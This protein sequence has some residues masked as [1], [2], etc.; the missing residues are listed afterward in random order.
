MRPPAGR[1]TPGSDR[2][3]R[4]GRASA[5]LELGD[6]NSRRGDAPNGPRVPSRAS[7]CIPAG[8]AGRPCSRR[9]AARTR[10]AG[11]PRGRRPRSP[12]RAPAIVLTR[13][14]GRSYAGRARRA[15]RGSDGRVRVPLRDRVP[16]LRPHSRRRRRR[17]ASPRRFGAGPPPAA[18]SALTITPNAIP[19]GRTRTLAIPGG[20][21]VPR[22][23]PRLARRRGH[24]R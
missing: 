24:G 4:R 2:G 18:R 13:A 1:G 3:S 5:A 7:P 19:G 21:V 14:R 10:D 9:R 22:R 15:S 23:G 6:G 20:S 17:R 16:G 8:R 12:R 11:A